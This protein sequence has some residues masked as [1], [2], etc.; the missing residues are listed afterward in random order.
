MQK[1]QIQNIFS[2]PVIVSN[3]SF[4]P[5]SFDAIAFSKSVQGESVLV[6]ATPMQ[7]NSNVYISDQPNLNEW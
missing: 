2:P 7:A 6:V 4:W 3:L 5:S 1:G